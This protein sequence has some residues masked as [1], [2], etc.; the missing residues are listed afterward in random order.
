MQGNR[1]R[2]HVLQKK[3]IVLQLSDF[4]YNKE[5][6]YLYKEVFMSKYTDYNF[7]ETTKTF[8]NLEGFKEPTP[9]QQAVIP[10]A[11]KGRNIIGISD[12]GTGKTH[13]FLIPIMERGGQQSV[14]DSGSY[15]GTDQRACLTDL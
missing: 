8:I 14:C 2:A 11:C 7:R 9:I 1:K 10:L 13:S 15:N 3:E 5:A 6:A 4:L 12:T